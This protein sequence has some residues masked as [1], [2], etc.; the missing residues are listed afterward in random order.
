MADQIKLKSVALNHN[1][2]RS[3]TCTRHPSHRQSP[4]V[5]SLC[6]NEKLARLSMPKSPLLM[7][8]ASS[9]VSS[10]SS[11]SEVSSCSSSEC[12]SPSEVRAKYAKRG[13]FSFVKRRQKDADDAVLSKSRSM[14]AAFVKEKKSG[15]GG[16]WSKV[17][18][19]TRRRKM[20]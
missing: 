8:G 7:L 13:S 20:E 5:C 4:G 11:L 19:R 18:K 17:L 3:R 14:A 1:F 12:I 16:F 2:Y 10:S 6:V 15:V 9:S